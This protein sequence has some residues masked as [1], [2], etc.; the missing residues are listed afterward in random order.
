MMMMAS[1]LKSYG[2]N[3]VR[4]LALKSRSSPASSSAL[5]AV[6]FS[7]HY[8]NRQHLHL[9]HIEGLRTVVSLR[10]FSSNSQGGGGGGGGIGRKQQQQQQQNQPKAFR[11]R[12]RASPTYRPIIQASSSSSLQKKTKKK[13][14]WMPGNDHK[15][16]TLGEVK[17]PKD[18]LEAEFGPLAAG[19]I[20]QMRKDN[21]N[22]HLKSK[23]DDLHEEELRAI[24][25]W[26][27]E[28]GSTEEL[29][30]ERRAFEQDSD[31]ERQEFY[32]N[33]ER[34]LK[35]A[36]KYDLDF[37]NDVYKTFKKN[38]L[39]E[40]EKFNRLFE[41][42]RGLEDLEEDNDDD[43][44]PDLV[45]DKNQLAH[46]EWSE[47]LVDVRRG[48]KLWRGGRLESYRALVI[49]GN[50]NGCAGF[51]IGKSPDAMKAV[52]LAG[53]NSKRNIFFVDRHQGDGLTRDLVGKM[54]SCKVIVRATDNGLRGNELCAEILMR[55]GITNAV[56]K[57][58]GNRHPW[59]V[60]RATFKAL[61]T[62]ESLEDIALKRGKRIVS[63][64]RALRMQ[65]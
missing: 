41:G 21:R 43:E 22:T 18:E 42:A 52:E 48:T 56:C 12:R 16:V 58:H 65:I 54:N 10:Q 64:E 5:T 4:R 26:T 15:F 44:D 32:A 38:P 35:R 53:R 30:F 6:V 60:V 2:I 39:A 25:Y 50:C 61:L 24:D 8:N 33:L 62:H 36:N 31:Q 11:P 51:G 27:S 3:A 34:E 7:D 46:G 1:T 57:A 49:G 63:I 55:F 29:V 13:K 40:K 19:V 28:R 9:P 14:E 47:M 45:F 20:R 17:N 37:D 23:E 59:N